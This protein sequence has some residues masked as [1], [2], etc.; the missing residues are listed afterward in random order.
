MFGRRMKRGR[1]RIGQFFNYF[2][3]HYIFTLSSVNSLKSMKFDLYN[4][5]YI[6]SNMKMSKLYRRIT[7][8]NYKIQGTSEGT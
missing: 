8:F 6:T 1:I 7:A 4:Y 3:L 5:K 2:H